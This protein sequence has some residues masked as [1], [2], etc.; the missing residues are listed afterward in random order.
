MSRA[1]G[2]QGRLG[3]IGM[4][5]I[6]DPPCQVAVVCINQIISVRLFFQI[7]DIFAVFVPKPFGDIGT[8]FQLAPG[9]VHFERTV[10]ASVRGLSWERPYR[11]D[12][13]AL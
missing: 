10:L 8:H 5:D 2:D 9:G 7:L 13:I 3:E 12:D 1:Q 11:V 6:V 4:A